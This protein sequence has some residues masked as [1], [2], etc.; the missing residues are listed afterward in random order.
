VK[1]NTAKGRKKWEMGNEVIVM[2]G[3]K[4]ILGSPTLE[5][6]GKRGDQGQT[7]TGAYPTILN[8]LRSFH[9]APTTK[10]VA[11]CGCSRTYKDRERL[12]SIATRH[13]IINSP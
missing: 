3:G 2:E 9:G 6:T 1:L 10:L 4:E 12:L 13:T 11:L 5:M 7:T 8:V